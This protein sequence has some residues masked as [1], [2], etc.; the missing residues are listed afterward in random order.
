MPA[1]L[2]TQQSISKKQNVIRFNFNRAEACRVNFHFELVLDTC[3]AVLSA[4]RPRGPLVD[5]RQTSKTSVNFPKNSNF[6]IA[7]RFEKNHLKFQLHFEGSTR[8][9]S[10]DSYTM[11]ETENRVFLVC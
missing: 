2:E 4:E 1:I 6:Q 10:P 11:R 7:G 5:R 9:A 3:F 8:H